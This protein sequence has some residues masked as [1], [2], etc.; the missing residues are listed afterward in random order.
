MK[1][2]NSGENVYLKANE[3]SLFIA[4]LALMLRCGLPL[5]KALEVFAESAEPTFEIVADRLLLEIM[6]GF[7]LSGAMS[8][9]PRSFSSYCCAAVQSGEVSGQLVACLER[10]AE[11]LEKRVAI[12]RKLKSALVYPCVLTVACF[13]MILIVL[14]LVFPMVV[15]V[16][17]QS[18]VEPPALT[19]L[20]VSVS[21]PNTLFAIMGVVF[22]IG[23]GV[24]LILR[25]EQ[26][27]ESFRRFLEMAT[28][29][30]R[31]LA[32]TQVSEACRQLAL[33]L[34]TGL[35]LSKALSVAARVAV[36]SVLVT[37]ALKSVRTEVIEGSE[38]S[39]ALG[40]F[41]VFPG[42]CSSLVAV[43][44]EGGTLGKSLTQ[45]ADMIDDDIDNRLEILSSLV[46]P[47][48]M[49]VAGVCVGT[50][51]LGAFLPLYNLV[52]L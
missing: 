1:D 2:F 20:L 17:A 28:P 10:L 6:A 9:Q 13:A 8:R 19:K 16:T 15:K 11:S 46:E 14:Y 50:V 32:R 27:S 26:R 24:V 5:G 52:A 22:L 29:P 12:V 30:G 33:M 42:F 7:T 38:L 36:K 41:P 18:G 51:L 45:A 4:Q 49:G 40:L 48:L 47:L 21:S 31:M 23:N 39:T 35:D 25:D 43:A 37:S 3:L 44:E 34:D